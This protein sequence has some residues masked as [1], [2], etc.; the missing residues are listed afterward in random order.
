MSMR[1]SGAHRTPFDRVNESIL[2]P[3]NH[4]SGRVGIGPLEIVGS[5]QL[6]VGAVLVLA[7]W[8]PLTLAAT[9]RLTQL[10]RAS[11][12]DVA[13]VAVG[14]GVPLLAGAWLVGAFA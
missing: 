10:G 11:T 8:V 14:W 2:S 7:A 13:K 9:Y 12:T 5:L 6:V 1:N 3:L 4:P